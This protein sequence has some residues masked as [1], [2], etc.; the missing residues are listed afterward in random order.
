MMNHPR[1]FMPVS[2]R[3]F[4]AV[5]LGLL[6]VSPTVFAAQGV[7]RVGLVD[8][9][10][11]LQKMPE[12]KQAETTLQATAVPLRK[13]LERLNQDMKNSIAFY[14]QQKASLGKPARMQ[15]EKELTLKAQSIQKYQQENSGVLEKKKQALFLPIRQKI[16]TAI[17]SIAQKNGFS[18]VLEKGAALYVTADH[19]LT[20]QVMA[21]LH[22]K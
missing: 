15:R 16:L 1:E 11:I 5:A 17:A 2:F 21:Q 18:V 12:T 22:I 7:E 3:F 20:S 6:L 14:E 10:K 4:T 8:S 19:D 9:G 13:E